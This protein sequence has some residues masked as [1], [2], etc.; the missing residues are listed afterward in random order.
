MARRSAQPSNPSASLFLLEE[1][2]L[3]LA[4]NAQPP[5]IRPGAGL[6]Q[7]SRELD[8]WLRGL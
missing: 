8:E 3:H 7:L 6:R 2:A 1:L 4:E 5:L